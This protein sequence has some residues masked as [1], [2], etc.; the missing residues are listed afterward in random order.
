MHVAKANA[1]RI[2]IFFRSDVRTSMKCTDSKTSKTHNS[3]WHGVYIKQDDEEGKW[4]TASV[5]VNHPNT[6]LIGKLK[7]C[8]VF[9]F[10]VS[11]RTNF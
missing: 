2:E 4:E 7:F 1:D 10:C 9:L 3:Q 8:T 11:S 6:P 5:L